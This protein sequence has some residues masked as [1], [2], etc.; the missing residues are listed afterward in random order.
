MFF[1]GLEAQKWCSCVGGVSI[2]LKLVIAELVPKMVRNGS[3]N[4]SQHGAKIAPWGLLGRIFVICG[5]LFGMS[6]FLDFLSAKSW[7]QIREKRV[8]GEVEGIISD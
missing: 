1:G 3:Q 6:F 2:L 7:Q 5:G 4:G 8:K